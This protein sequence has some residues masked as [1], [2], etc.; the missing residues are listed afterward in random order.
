MR[1]RHRVSLFY[2]ALLHV[3]PRPFRDEFGDEM[4]EFLRSRHQ[5]ASAQGARARWQFWSAF[6]LDLANS[7]W[8]QRRPAADGS[9]F[10]R[11]LFF[12]LIDDVRSAARV[13]RRSPALTSIIVLLMALGLGAATIV[14]SVV[15]SVLLRALPFGDPDRLVVLWESRPERHLERN[16]VSGHEFPEWSRRSRSLERMS[17][18]SFPG[19]M[20]LTGTGDPH[21]LAVVRVSA[22]F[23]EVLGVKP[24]LGRGFRDDEDV[25]GRGQVVLLSHHVWRDRFGRD[26]AILGRAVSFDGRP[27]EVVGVMPPA[28]GFPPGLAATPPDVWMPIAEPIHLYRGRHYLYV[29]GRLPEAVTIAEAQEDMS[30]VA[31]E[32]RAELPELNRGHDVRVVPLH[33]DLVRNSRDSLLLVFGAVSCLLLIGCANVA[34]LL[35]ARGIARRREIS[36]RLALGAS[37]SRVA[38]QLL[39]ESVLLSLAGGLLGVAAAYGFTRVLPA[40]VPIDVMRLESVPVDVTVLAVSLTLSVVTGLVFGI[41]PVLQLRRVNLSETLKRGGRTNAA[42]VKP[43]LRRVLVA[44][45]IAL[46]LMLVFAAGLMVRG[47]TELQRVDPGFRPSGVLAVDVNLPAVRYRQGFRQRQFFQDAVARISALPGVVSATTANAVPLG[48]SYSSIAVNI[49]GR[50]ARAPADDEPSARYRIVGPRYFKTMGIPL[51][52]GREFAA[53]DARVALPLIRWFPQ[54][55]LPDGFDRPQPVPVAVINEAMARLYWPG[56]NPFGR[57]FSLLSSPPIEIVGIA[58]DTRNDSLQDAPKPEVY[59]SDL[60]EPATSSTVLVRTGGEPEDLI[61]DVRSAIWS[62]DRDL[63]LGSITT[64]DAVVRRTFSLSQFTSALV[65][66]FAV[67]AL[68]LMTAGVYGLI[69]FTTS[70]RLPEIGVRLALGAERAA[71]L[72]MIIREGLLLAGAGMAAGLAAALTVSQLLRELVFGVAPTD[73]LTMVIVI[74]LMT[75]AVIAASW[76]PARRASRTDPLAVLRAE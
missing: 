65:A 2:R 8:R 26:P 38:R 37:V 25:P 61:A 50:P 68:L 27:F 71:I 24:A 69:A 14:F 40:L 70:A 3:Y 59:L 64:M 5:R 1:K 21:A 56:E 6:V 20:T 57:R 67:S 55:P 33:D 54:Q 49:E 43:R 10:G 34:G 76:L 42:S 63:P 31:A 47:L 19:T 46:T 22:G 52:A 62:L 32:L 60:Q 15:N 30:R 45:Q 13:L 17:A 7:A 23:T 29:V 16:A 72:R 36:L 53:A 48:G 9:G 18:F 44:G 41:A 4:A 73:P 35:V 51:V 74:A 66:G 58:A 39:A 28:F 12:S 11:T 75:L